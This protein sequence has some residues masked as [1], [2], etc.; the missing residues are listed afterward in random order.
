[1]PFKIR[2]VAEGER[3]IFADAPSRTVARLVIAQFE[4]ILPTSEETY[5]YS[6]D[7][8]R[9]LGGHR[10]R[11]NTFAFSH[12]SATQENPTGE[13][14]LTAAFLAERGY[15]L[16]DEVMSARYVTVP[17]VARKHELILF[18]IEPLEP[19]GARLA[20]LYSGDAETEAW[21]A[22]GAALVE[23]AE[24]AFSVLPPDTTLSR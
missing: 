16:A 22:I 24:R 19:A 2:D 9:E 13:A 4:G 18:Y 11:R 17:D 21:R 15:R 3:F 20:E 7:D 6:F 1:V 23:R 8:A 10:F 14:A 12:A 5:R